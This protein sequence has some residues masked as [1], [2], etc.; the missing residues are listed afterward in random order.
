M[1]KEPIGKP[2]W[3]LVLAS[4]IVAML[5]I[6]LWYTEEI[7]ST[8]IV[9]GCGEEVCMDSTH[10]GWGKVVENT[11]QYGTKAWFTMCYNQYDTYEKRIRFCR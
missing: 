7:T 1:K 8:I 3:Y 9:Q 6:A 11:P 2:F 4:F 5:A 10:T